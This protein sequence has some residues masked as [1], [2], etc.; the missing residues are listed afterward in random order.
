MLWPPDRPPI[1][2][3][4]ISGRGGKDAESDDVLLARATA[5]TLGALR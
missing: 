4:V 2:L 1:V 3:A 5:L